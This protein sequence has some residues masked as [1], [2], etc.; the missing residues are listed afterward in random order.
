MSHRQTDPDNVVL[1]ID[2]RLPLWGIL[3]ALGMIAGQAALMYM[4]QREQA[5]SLQQLVVANAS[6]DTQLK[7]LRAEVRGKE[8]KDYTHDAKLQE[9]EMRLRIIETA[10]TTPK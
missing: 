4:T 7:E 5:I 9:L 3:S 2:R 10:K 6:L 1:P 8:A